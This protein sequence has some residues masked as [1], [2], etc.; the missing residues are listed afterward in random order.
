LSS[1]VAIRSLRGIG[2]VVEEDAR[3]DCAHTGSGTRAR[4]SAHAAYHLALPCPRREP[5]AA[6][7]RGAQPPGDELRTA[8]SP[9]TTVPT[10]KHN[11]NDLTSTI[12]RIADGECLI[13]RM[14]SLG[15]RNSTT[16]GIF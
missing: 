3:Q 7:A 2:Y 8:V 6:T 11:T 12:Q 15:C 13:Q 10:R 9:G 1:G 14:E 5:T 16:K 4:A